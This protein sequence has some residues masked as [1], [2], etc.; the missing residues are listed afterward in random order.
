MSNISFV[1]LW[2]AN[3][4]LWMQLTI[5]ILCVFLA[6]FIWAGFVYAMWIIYRFTVSVFI[7]A[8][9]VMLIV[10][11]PYLIWQ[12]TVILGD[13]IA[14]L[15]GSIFWL[16]YKKYE[17]AKEYSF[18]S[19][20]ILECL[21]VIGL[22]WTFRYQPNSTFVVRLKAIWTKAK[23]CFNNSLKLDIMN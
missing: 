9:W 8:I 7:A 10:G 18:L 11:I 17:L 15:I 2:I 23:I 16:S 12:L 14:Y 4:P 6:Q 13:Q 1:F 21:I 3:Q 22:I 5:I 20:L 19:L